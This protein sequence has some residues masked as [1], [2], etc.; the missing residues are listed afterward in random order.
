MW[1]V[2]DLFRVNKRA[3]F[4]QKYSKESLENRPMILDGFLQLKFKKK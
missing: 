4:A 3:T 2:K 1:T